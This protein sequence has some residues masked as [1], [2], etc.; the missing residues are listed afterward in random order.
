M[1][2]NRKSNASPGE[3]RDQTLAGLSTCQ[4]SQILYSIRDQ[5]HTSNNANE[6][7]LYQTRLRRLCGLLLLENNTSNDVILTNRLGTDPYARWCE[8]TDREIIPIFLLDSDLF[9]T[10]YIC[11][12]AQY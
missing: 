12:S 10:E 6:F 2:D 8:G 3:T 11:F 4:H 5:C 9:R 1:E 7:V